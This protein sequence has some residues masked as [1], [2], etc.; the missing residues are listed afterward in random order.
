MLKSNLEKVVQH[1]KRA[2]SIVKNMLLHSRSGS[3]EHRP[4]EINAV[5]E[6]SL[7]L[8]YHGARAEEQDF[9]ITL[10]RDFD[11]G[12]GIADIYPQEIRGTISKGFSEPARCG[13]QQR[14]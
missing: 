8:A 11:P 4:V 13:L 3:G 7:N 12:A 14:L 6:E 5:V 1:G 9:K 2:D 10:E